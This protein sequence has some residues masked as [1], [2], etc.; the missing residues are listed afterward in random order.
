M[1]LRVSHVLELLLSNLNFHLVASHGEQSAT[2]VEGIRRLR[3][4]ERKRQITVCPVSEVE[5]SRGRGNLW[6]Y[7]FPFVSLRPESGTSQVSF[8][9]KKEIPRVQGWH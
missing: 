9:P 8:T 7:F 4:V 5:K 6:K 1:L 2:Y 3:E